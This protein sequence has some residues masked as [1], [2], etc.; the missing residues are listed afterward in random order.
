MPDIEL[1]AGT[2]T[3]EDTGGDGP[4]VVLVH[5][6]VMDSSVWREVIADL[7]RDFRCVAP[8]LPLGAHRTPMHPDADLT[9]V[10]QARLMAEFV[11][12]LDL[13]NVTLVQNDS[14]YGQL[15]AGDRPPWLRTLVLVATAA[16]DNYPPGLPGKMLGVAGK[17]ARRLK[18]FMDP[19]RF[20]PVQLLF[21]SF[22]AKKPISRHLIDRW[23]EPVW[24]NPLIRR[25]LVRFCA[26]AHPD[27]MQKAAAR[28]D[29]YDGSALVVW[30]ANDRM[31]PAAH[32]PRLAKLLGA[33]LVIVPDSRTL[34][35]LDQPAAL[36]KAIR[37]LSFAAI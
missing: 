8:T 37:D 7:R 35:P 33:P 28:L 27:T 4:T 19:L 3:Y 6:P 15:V 20:R 32:G 26:G 21:S 18:F 34:V 22:M 30:A 10:G 25:D 17:S 5:G 2:I 14:G 36:T 13:K 31:M 1:S 29:N 12:K 11:E 24:T 23:F 16:F 9:P